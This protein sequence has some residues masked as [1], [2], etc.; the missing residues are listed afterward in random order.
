MDEEDRPTFRPSCFDAI[1]DKYATWTQ[2]RTLSDI[3]R[4]ALCS[5]VTWYK[6]PTYR[7]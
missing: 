5:V 1:L 6:P 4:T 7:L 3:A 2:E